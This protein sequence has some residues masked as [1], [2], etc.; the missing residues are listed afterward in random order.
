MI[1]T[2]DSV[3]D[4]LREVN[5]DYYG[6]NTWNQAFGQVDL[7]KQVAEESLLDSYNENMVNAY[8]TAM[9]NKQSIYGS[10]LGQ[11][12]K[13]LAADESD[14]ALNQAF[15]SYRQN[16]AQSQSELE[17]TAQ[18]AIGNINSALNNQSA[19]VANLANRAF[20]WLPYL[21]KN[22]EELFSNNAL[23]G[24]FATRDESG[25]VN[26]VMSL[27]EMQ[28]AMF[29]EDG[30]LNEAGV[31]FMNMVTKYGGN[32]ELG[33]NTFTQFLYEEDKELL[34]WLSSAD[35]YSPGKT[36]MD[37]FN[38]ILGI[39]DGAYEFDPSTLTDDQAAGI[40]NQY[41]ITRNELIANRDKALEGDIDLN[42]YLANQEASTKQLAAMAKSLGI[43]DQVKDVLDSALSNLDTYKT[44]GE[45][46]EEW[47]ITQSMADYD[48]LYNAVMS[49][50]NSKF[51]P[52]EVTGRTANYDLVDEQITDLYKNKD[53]TEDQFSRDARK[54]LKSYGT[55]DLNDD[56][57]DKAVI[58]PYGASSITL[59]YETSNAGTED[60][61]L[62]FVLKQPVDGTG[63]KSLKSLNYDGDSF[64]IGRIGN[65]GIVKYKGE[66]YE[67][68]N[69]FDTADNRAFMLYLRSFEK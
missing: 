8:L 54:I 20:E 29:N 55:F 32:G 59:S 45:D 52:V 41:S 24:R 37:T 1:F 56:E 9:N 43:Y 60:V 64:E 39:G 63:F 58:N 21:Y 22:N 44:K 46:E 34:N 51:T 42:T 35:P 61:Q 40:S 67:I 66:Y 3:R 50:V 23:L 31:E 68:N 36:N 28:S 33:D 4:Q 26:G 47:A 15:E 18:T 65:K 16:F 2:A 14:M 27:P 10:N 13:N 38:A 19:N 11:G 62:N 57:L 6:R 30:S 48:E 69:A 53:L 5:K 17:A 25:R 12:Y 49:K 7:Q